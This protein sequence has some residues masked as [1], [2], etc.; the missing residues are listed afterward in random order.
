MTMSNK[1]C[2]FHSTLHNSKVF[3][4]VSHYL[5]MLNILERSFYTMVLCTLLELGSVSNILSLCFVVF[6]CVADAP[7][8]V[9]EVLNDLRGT[10]VV[11]QLFL[12]SVFSQLF[13]QSQL[14]EEE[15]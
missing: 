10:Y 15:T 11:M 6:A 12:S 5:Q 7:V 13:M 4:P 2:G 9:A 3:F 14:R 8:P 1:A